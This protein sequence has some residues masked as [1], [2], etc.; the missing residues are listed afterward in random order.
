M[1]V[2]G[3]ADSDDRSFEVQSQAGA[4]LLLVDGGGLT[5]VAAITETNGVLRSN[6]LTNS[7]FDV[8]SNSTL[9]SATT[10]AAPSSE[11]AGDLIHAGTA[12]SGT[13][14]TGATGTTAP[15][16]WTAR[17][18]SGSGTEAFTITGSGQAGNCIDITRTS[19]LVGIEDAI[20]TVVGKLYKLT[21]WQKNNSGGGRVKVTT[22][23]YWGG[24][25]LY[26]SGDISNVGWTEY[27]AVFEATTTTTYIG[28][29]HAAGSATQFD[30]VSVH[31]V[32]PGCV[33]SGAEQ[34]DGWQ[35]RGGTATKCWRQH[36]DGDTEEVT[37]LGSFYSLKTVSTT[38]AWNH[39]WPAATLITDAN[40]LARFAGRTVTAGCWVYSTIDPPEIR[41]N[42][43]VVAGGVG[44]DNYSTQTVAQNTWTWLETTVACPDALANFQVQLNKSG[45]T[46]ETYY[47]SQV[48]LSLGSAV[49]EGNYSRPSGEVIWLE[50]EVASNLLNNTTGHSDTDWTPLNVAADSNGRV[51][52]GAKAVAMQIRLNDSASSSGSE[53]D[54]QLGAY[55][56]ASSTGNNR[57]WSADILGIAD[58]KPQRRNGWIP[59]NS[60]GNPD[61]SIGATGSGTLDI[62]LAHY[63]G[64][65]LR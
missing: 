56:S 10:G 31:E 39:A 28:L 6:L 65:E 4:Q 15:N 35:R 57:Q 42:I 12:N 59:C 36:S 58:D 47:V 54:V 1:Q 9:V 41:L 19:G 52:K 30:T 48:C 11:D 7:G 53:A 25:V 22:G 27:T 23:T 13:A 34:C 5:T 38:S 64:V 33:S 17:S 29:A 44:T 20:T 43:H 45:A 50:N 37:K 40:L 14:W 55:D 26:D 21:Y 51:P 49:G 18:L 61:Y 8:W 16:G 46:S 60:T 24:T 32:V 3:G 2:K 63:Y 62:P